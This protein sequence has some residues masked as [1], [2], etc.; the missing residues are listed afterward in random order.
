MK[1]VL[2]LEN[3]IIPSNVGFK[4]LNPQSKVIFDAANYPYRGW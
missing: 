3:G 1:V 2:A 4:K